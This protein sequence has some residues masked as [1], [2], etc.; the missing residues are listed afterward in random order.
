[1]SVIVQ[2]PPYTNFHKEFV[3]GETVAQLVQRIKDDDKLQFRGGWAVQDTQDGRVLDPSEKVVD[4]R[5]Y[6]LTV[7]IAV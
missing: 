3:P 6:Y 5:L 2:T 1:M 7:W 4:N